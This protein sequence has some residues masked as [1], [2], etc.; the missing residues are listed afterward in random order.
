M[1]G[2]TYG[3]VLDEHYYKMVGHVL[4]VSEKILTPG[5]YAVEALPFL[6]HVPSWVPGIGFKRFAAEAR[7]DV[8]TVV[9]TLFGTARDKVVLIDVNVY[10]KS[11]LIIRHCG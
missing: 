11:P 3:I 10:V 1:I 9:D 4:D 5:R 7:K 6:R 8:T 2:V